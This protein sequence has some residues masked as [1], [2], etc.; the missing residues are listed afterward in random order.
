MQP[1]TYQEDSERLSEDDAAGYKQKDIP[2][3]YTLASLDGFLRKECSDEYKD[4]PSIDLFAFSTTPDHLAPGD[5]TDEDHLPLCDTRLYIGQSTGEFTP[6]KPVYLCIGGEGNTHVSLICGDKIYKSNFDNVAYI[7]MNEPLR[8]LCCSGNLMLKSEVG[9]NRLKA[10]V[11][12]LFLRA[13]HNQTVLSYRGLQNDLRL[14]C[15]WLARKDD[16]PVRT[17]RQR[18]ALERK[19]EEAAQKR[20]SKSRQVTS[21]PA[22]VRDGLQES[23]IFSTNLDAQDT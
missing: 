21:K 2:V 16:G 5:T 23:H 14:A 9:K 19:K 12:Y 3:T 15:T 22:C 1:I 18:A 11:C 8:K 6:G 10:Y 7:D 4:L 20:I 17:A 13:G